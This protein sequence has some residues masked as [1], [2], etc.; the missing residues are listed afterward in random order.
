YIRIEN[1]IIQFISK[2][3]G[4]YKV[5][6]CVVA[7]VTRNADI[8][9]DDEKF[10]DV[11]SDFRSR[12]TSLLKNR[13]HLNVIRLEVSNIISESFLTRLTNIVSVD[14]KFVY[15]DSCP[16]KMGYV[17]QLESLLNE[18]QKNELLYTPH[19]PRWPED[20]DKNHAIIDQIQ[21]GDKLLF[22]PYDSTEPFLKLLSEAAENKNVVSIKITIYRLAS[23]SKIARLLCRAAENGKQVIVM[24]ELRARFDEA[25]NIEWS[26]IL[27]SA[28]CQILY[29]VEDF[30]CHSKI[31]QI[32][33]RNKGNLH[34]ITQI[35]TGN[36]NEKTNTMYTDLSLITAS[37]SIGEDAT[38]FFQNLLVNNLNGEY[39]ELIVS[40]EGIENSVINLIEEQIQKGDNGYICIKINSLT[41]YELI[42]KLVQ[43]SQA[44]VHI[45]LIIRGICCLLPGIKGYTENIHITSIVGRFLEHARI[46]CFGKGDNSKIYISSADF[47]GRNLHHRVE[48]ACPIESP[49]IKN[50]LSWILSSQLKDNIKAS[51]ITSNGLFK[52]KICLSKIQY[53]SQDYFINNTM[54]KSIYSIP[55]KLTV[56]QKLLKH[57]PFSH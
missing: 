31:C 52:R 12:V 14:S 30:K 41:D 11:A 16:L 54:H 37:K 28:G 20:I 4:S 47:M 6:E 2:L 50:E 7:S 48:I 15:I 17:F 27:E 18:K 24:M 35:G 23:S 57:L 51:N 34:Y 26:K 19:N 55:K 46:Y 56:F 22:F 9:F 10:E 25:N 49:E 5:I 45:E 40:P 8:R 36:Y 1:I 32:T 29:G 39:K 33:L 13:D 53:D 42:E 21:K 44:G 3:F 38:A 43:A